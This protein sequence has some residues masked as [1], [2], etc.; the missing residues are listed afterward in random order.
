MKIRR[1][2]RPA[3]SWMRWHPNTFL[4]QDI[5]YVVEVSNNA[6]DW[7]DIT[8]EIGDRILRKKPGQVRYYL[9]AVTCNECG[10]PYFKRTALARHLYRDHH[11]LAGKV[12]DVLENIEDEEVE[13]TWSR[14]DLYYESVLPREMPKLPRS[15]EV[16]TSKIIKKGTRA[17]T[18]EEREEHDRQM[19][20][21]R[22]WNLERKGKPILHRLPNGLFEEKNGDVDIWLPQV[23]EDGKWCP[24]T[25]KECLNWAK[26]TK[27][28][29]VLSL[30]LI[31]PW[32]R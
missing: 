3:N 29:R 27:K 2:K 5:D 24:A 9:N 31:V 16:Q 10:T 7:D 22:K 21:W 6:K 15:V 23:L 26:L 11:Y 30:L 19:C 28:K 8:A 17:P 12:N 4:N 20:I 1:V 14:V 18:A 25:E 13:I 32:T